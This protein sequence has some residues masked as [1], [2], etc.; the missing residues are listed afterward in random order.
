M[1]G[2]IFTSKIRIKIMKFLFFEKDETYIREISNVLNVPVSGVKREIDNLKKLGLVKKGK[3]VLLNKDFSILEDLKNIFI[4]VDY[5]GYPIQKVLEKT[6]VKF[7]LLF[8]SFAKGD[9]SIGSDIDLLIIGEIKSSEV[10]KK[11]KP[12]EG[13]IGRDINSV[14]WDE[15][16]LKRK[17][18]SA[19]V[20]E[21]FAN[22]IIMIKGDEK[23]VRE[24][25]R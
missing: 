5:V 19:F 24:F 8:G 1:L 16:E 21:I 22:K 6:S 15:S 23:N 18:N 9:Y 2:K 7:G 10:F 12:V 3:K 17:K 11:L 25:I 20:K 14:V 4:K 13:M